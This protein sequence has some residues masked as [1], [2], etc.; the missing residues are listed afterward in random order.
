MSPGTEAH[1]KI[2]EAFGEGILNPD[3]TVDRKALGRI[4]FT[5]EQSRAL[6]NQ[7]MHPAVHAEI[8]RRIFELESRLTYGIVIVHA[9]LL[10]ESGH[11]KMYDRLIVVTC[12][13]KLQL[14]RIVG[15]GLTLEEAA[16]RF[17]A[18]MPTEQKLRLADYT[19][20][21]SGPL[22]ETKRQIEAIYR[23]L[24]TQELSTR[25]NPE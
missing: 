9:A 3:G 6:I 11:Y 18:Q 7:L 20:E 19:I 14:A 1:A 13:P 23:D 12:D 10:V 17:A 2:V 25:D 24:M 21:T 22:R 16:Q 8:L 5:D 4:V 15:R